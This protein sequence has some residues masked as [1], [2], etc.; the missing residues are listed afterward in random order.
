MTRLNRAKDYT[1]C[2]IA[3]YKGWQK[4]QN[5]QILDVKRRVLKN[6]LSRG[7]NRLSEA[8]KVKTNNSALLPSNY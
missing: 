4:M 6:D 1:G 7:N 2:R 3:N 5:L 8:R